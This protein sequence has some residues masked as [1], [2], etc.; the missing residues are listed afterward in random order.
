MNGKAETPRQTLYRMAN[1][2]LKDFSFAIRFW[3]EVISTPHYLQNQETVVG[4]NISPFELGI[5]RS[6][7]LS[8][9]QQIVPRRVA[10]LPKLSTG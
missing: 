1:A 10:Q 6:R 4:R 9:L 8:H 2:F 5:G 7:L 3:P